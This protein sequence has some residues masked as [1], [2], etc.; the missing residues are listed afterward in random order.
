[1][2]DWRRYCPT[3]G[4]RKWCRKIPRLIGISE[5][6]RKHVCL[7]Q[8]PKKVKWRVCT[9]IQF[10]KK[11][12]EEKRK[13]LTRWLTIGEAGIDRELQ[14]MD[15]RLGLSFVTD[16]YVGNKQVWQQS[17]AACRKP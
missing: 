15:A 3:L 11:I 13:A 6:T 12:V 16:I 2:R 4:S 14:G 8:M 5:S 10:Q 17:N 7:R 9:W 1:M